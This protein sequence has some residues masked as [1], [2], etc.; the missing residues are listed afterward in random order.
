M[1]LV[2]RDTKVLP[3]VRVSGR[4]RFEGAAPGRVTIRLTSPFQYALPLE[5]Q[6]RADGS[7]EF[8]NVRPGGHSG[9]ILA[10]TDAVAART[11]FWV[12]VTDRSIEG[13][14][15]QLPALKTVKVVTTHNWPGT[16]PTYAVNLRRVDP[17]G[18]NLEW[19]LLVKP[20]TA[21]LQVPVGEFNVNGSSGSGT[22]ISSMTYGGVDVLRDW[23]ITIR[24]DEAGELHVGLRL[25]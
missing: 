5:T 20:G 15:M 7:F 2:L 8:L 9:E 13:M 22:I 11:L 16:L 25:R 4:V 17:R 3:A 18:E 24:P 19:A 10:S 12:T 21:T 14:D 23:R 6:A 1:R